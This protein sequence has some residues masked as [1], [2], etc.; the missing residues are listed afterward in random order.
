MNSVSVLK[1][2]K[3]GKYDYIYIYFKHKGN[4]IRINTQQKYIQGCHKKDLFYN[5]K[6]PNYI[7]LNQEIKNLKNKVDQ[8]IIYKMR[9][10]RPDINQKGCQHYIKTGNFEIDNQRLR[11]HL[12]E[13]A[14]PKDLTLIEHYTDFLQHKQKQ[15]NGS[16]SIKDYKSLGIALQKYEELNNLTL[17]LESINSRDFFN[18]FRNYLGNNHNNNT[19]SKRIS[20]LKTFMLWVETEE[21][22]S[23]K[24][25]L[26]KFKVE[27]YKPKYVT[28][29]RQEIQEIQDLK[30]EKKNWQKIIDVFVCNCFMGMR[31][32]DLM[33]M[34]KG[35]FLQD[36]DGS[37]Y[38]T[39]INEKTGKPILIEV[40]KTSL[41]IL[42]KYDF[43]LP[44]YSNQ[45]FNRK[46]QDIL[47]VYDLFNTK[48]KKP[49]KQGGKNI[50]KPLL[51]RE[52]ITSHTA[53]RTYITL[54]I[55]NK[56]PLNT[57]KLATGHTQLS[58][59]SGYA[60]D[61]RNKEAVQA[62]D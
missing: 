27:T 23:Y 18:M 47:K 5:T 22:Y 30:I 29:N 57:I 58:T 46:L 17:T 50:T 39:K 20:N 59:L 31:I 28:L 44:T 2:W 32:S 55:S 3:S 24:G 4:I 8:Y 49:Y 26:Y 21:L 25:F 36:D 62:I 60:N 48:V 15:F 45:Y 33:T 14:P 9:H 37:Y 38:Y 12:I 6:M 51:K 35:E 54:S 16:D 41:A 43:K 53:R 40:T 13:L 34:E 19:T 7:G 56:V 10:W 61:E 42:K 11:Q 52:M 1:N